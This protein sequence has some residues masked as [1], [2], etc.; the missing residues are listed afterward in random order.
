ML[1]YKADIFIKVAQT[2][3]IS[4]AARELNISQ[5]AVS[6]AVQKLEEQFG[7]K[8]FFRLPRGLELTP[9]GSLLLKHLRELKN[10]ATEA[11]SEMAAARG[12]VEGQ[13]RLGACPTF[14]EYILPGLLGPFSRRHPRIGY[15]LAIG[16]NRQVY[17]LLKEGRVELAF[18]AGKPPVRKLATYKIMEDELILIVPPGHPWSTRRELEKKELP[19]QPL[20][21]R[22]RGSGSRKETEEALSEMG[23]PPEKLKVIAEF[24]SLEAIKG[25]V[26]AG[27]GAALISRWAVARE[28]QLKTLVPV[29]IKDGSLHREIHAA[30]LP[31]P[32]LTA[33]AAR[34][35]ELCRN[36]A[37]EHPEFTSCPA[38]V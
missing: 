4:R 37:Q 2:K 28:V 25:A 1:D 22:E 38:K 27:L 11:E 36:L 29:R 5:P 21:M 14:G 3:N 35:L 26:A 9:A 19:E 23:L 34:L 24:H 30:H 10:R 7:V 31:E 17:G 18:L 16:N 20:I 6:A 32:P 8:L 12:T 15:S 33:A 13:L